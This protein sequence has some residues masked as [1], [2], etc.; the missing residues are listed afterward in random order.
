MVHG[1]IKCI[2]TYVMT[3]YIRVFS[4]RSRN[5]NQ[6][7]CCDAQLAFGGTVRGNVPGFVCGNFS[8]RGRG[9][10]II[11]IYSC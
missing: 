6:P 9:R 1:C 4:L 10:V 2:Y 11:I 5:N 7:M 8:G 3:V